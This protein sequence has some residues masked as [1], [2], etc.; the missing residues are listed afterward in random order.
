MIPTMEYQQIYHLW[1]WL[2]VSILQR[3]YI[4]LVFCESIFIVSSFMWVG[5]RVSNIA[6]LKNKFAK[7]K[8][9]KGGCEPNERFKFH[10][11]VL[12]MFFFLFCLV[13]HQ[14]SN[15]KTKFFNFSFN[16]LFGSLLIFLMKHQKKIFNQ[17]KSLAF[18]F[19]YIQQ[20]QVCLIAFCH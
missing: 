17:N 16:F 5:W 13:F 18:W 14:K 2:A 20:Q 9:E 7:H 15:F 8:L 12:Q 10:E 1:S 11:H 3:I 4:F 19:I 6:K